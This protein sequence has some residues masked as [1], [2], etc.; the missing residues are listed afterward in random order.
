[1]GLD[2][3]E[4]VL[5]TEDEFGISIPDG[6]AAV[7]RTPRMLAE[8]VSSRLAT[9]GRSNGKPC[10]SQ[11][12]FYRLRAFL[13]E[14]FGLERSAIKPSSTLKNLL[15]PTTNR[16]WTAIKTTIGTHEMPGLRP[17]RSIDLLLKSVPFFTIFVF[18]LSGFELKIGLMVFMVAWIFS[19][20]LASRFATE[21]PLK[22]CLISDLLPF[23]RVPEV[24]SVSPAEVLQRILR[25]TSEQLD[26]PLERIQPDHDFVED[27]GMG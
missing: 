14:Q 15:T 25:I 6:D 26:I 4:L 17:K 8:Y 3:V 27:L 5:A 23:I 22:I 12:Q 2:S 7:I 24:Q 21:L 16:Y 20:N 19:I 11:A 9:E 1:M 18:M 13:V 10:V